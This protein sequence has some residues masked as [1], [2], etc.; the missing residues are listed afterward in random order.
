MRSLRRPV[1]LARLAR[2]LMALAVVPVL[3]ACVSQEKYDSLLTSYRAQEQQYIQAQSDLAT[4]RSNEER[5]RQQLA[6][7]AASLEELKGLQGADKAEIERLVADYKRLMDELGNIKVGPLPA[8]LTEALRQL[9]AQYPDMLSFDERTGMLRFASDFTFDSGSAQLKAGTS[10]AISRLAQILNSGEARPFEVKVVGHTDNQPINRVRAEHPTNM[11]LSA[12]RAISVRDALVRDG[13][14]A[15]RM[16]VAGYG[17]FRPMVENGPRGAAQNRRVEI[18]LTPL[19]VPLVD[20]QPGVSSGSSGRS[21]P[22]STAPA[23]R[24]PVDDEPTK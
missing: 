18:F 13:V 16:Q 22:S 8:A 10:A 5:L 11:H 23:R 17:E 1:R 12:H 19:T 4:S 24:Q 15:N 2:L 7:A 9:A 14:S 3:G 21:V 20:V 6:L